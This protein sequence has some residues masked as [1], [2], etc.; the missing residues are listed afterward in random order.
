MLFWMNQRRYPSTVLINQGG[1]WVVVVGFVTDVA[2]VGGS[3]P[4]LQSI[5]FHDPEPH[6]V[7]TDTTMTGA[8][9]Y[10]GPW[11]GSIVYAGW[12]NQ[13]VAV[14]EPPIERGKVRVEHV[15]RTGRR[16]LRPTQAAAHARK[17]IAELKLGTQSKYSVLNHRDAVLM[18]PMLVREENPRRRAKNA[19]YYYI[20]PFGFKDDLDERGSR[21]ARVCV[22]VNAYTGQFE[23]VTAFGKP[24]RY[25]PK[26]EA[27]DVVAAAW[28]M[29]RRR[30]R[31]SSVTLMFQPSEITH[32]RTFPFWCVTIDKRTVYVDQLGKLYGTLLPSGP[33][34]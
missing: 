11:N 8:Q 9:W 21:L 2:P 17:W 5:S 15:T 19:P 4:V 32:V 29:P 34:D 31:V 1:H 14:V 23:E 33:G 27:L 20:V 25:L 18:D 7:G 3:S 16:L 28:R 26:E 24:V 6:N 12:L 13:Y 10:A 30:L 22:L